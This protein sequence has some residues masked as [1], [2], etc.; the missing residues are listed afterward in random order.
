MDNEISNLDTL[1]KVK[2]FKIL[3]L[4]VRSLPKK[5]DQIRLMLLKSN[6]EVITLSETW[7]NNSVSSISLS[8]DDYKLFRQDR[9]HVLVNK[10]K[11]GGLLTYV[12]NDLAADCE[13]LVDISTATKDIEAQWSQIT[14]PHC[15]NVVVCNVYRP[16]TGKLDNAIKY[17]DECLKGFDLGKVEVYIMGDMNVNYKN[18]SAVDFKKLNFFIKSN[19]LSQA[20]DKTTRNTDKTKSL[21]DLILTNSLYVKAAGTLEH[22]I[23]DHQP[24]FIVKKKG[25]DRRP[26]VIFEGRTYR[27]YDKE[28][29]K[30]RLLSQ[31]WD[32]YFKI[33]DPDEAWDHILTKFMPVIDEMCPIRS[34]HIKNYK[35]DW[36]NSELL[37][38]IK[39]RDYFYKKAKLTGD[40]DDWNIA[41]HL[42]NVTNANIRQAKRDFIVDELQDNKSD[43][44]QF[45]KT[46][47]SVIPSDKGDARQNINLTQQGVKIAK[48]KV[49]DHIND[50]FINIGKQQPGNTIHQTQ[51]SDGSVSEEV[52]SVSVFSQSE[53]LKAV[54]S[55]NTSKSLGL[56]NISSFVIKEVFIILIPQITYLFNLSIRM[57]IFPCVWKEALVI[58]IPKCGNLS[59]VKNYRPISLLPIPG[60]LLEKLVH[61]QLSEYLDE[62]SFLTDNQHGFRKNHSTLHSVA[63]VVNYV[64]LK[65]DRRLPTLAAFIDFR[66]V[67]DCVQHPILLDKLSTIGLHKNLVSWFSSYLTGRKQRVLANNV[68]SASK[69]VTQG[70]PQ[71]SVLGPLFY[72]IYANDIAEIMKNCNLALY[73]DDTVLY[74]AGS[75]FNRIVGKMQKDIDAL[76][77]WCLNN[78]I[79]MN[80]DKTNLMLFGQ[81]SMLDKLPSFEINVN[82]TP[83]KAVNNY[84]YLGMTLDCQLNYNKHVQ[85]N[86]AKV[87]VKL[88]Q[89]RRMRYFL[90]TKAAMLVYK[91]MI[92]PML[93]YGD[94]FMSSATVNDRKK[95]QV[96]QNKGLRCALQVDK[97][98]D[99]VELHTE[100]KLCKLN[101]RRELHLMSHMYDMAQCNSNLKARAVDGVKTRSSEKK[102]LKI[103]KPATEKF[104]KSLAYKDP[105]KWNALPT[106]LHQLDTRAKFNSGFKI[107]MA[108]KVK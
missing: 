11:G 73:A 2:G 91:N 104:K 8:L 97:Y 19:G 55:I 90:D 71:G 108:E 41:K 51:A 5:M 103:K 48:S 99:T 62:I 92:L 25:R 30:Q 59:L 23:S 94:I 93:E 81:K 80:T 102:L 22:F 17:L 32:E 101:R 34:F 82:D 18:K 1:N 70:V 60:K 105:K 87:S 43:Y 31:N 36:I 83:I 27:S 47:R 75:N 3:H 46:I 68:Y 13:P 106:R 6:L 33:Q 4:N 57:S 72:I 96:L 84:R 26:S 67:F 54:K 12:R 28:V 9:N 21:L 24:I 15:K 85:K 56:T 69:T 86:I 76:S 61:T 58:P 79:Q 29:M 50:Y 66:K 14:R 45:W 74:I 107:F 100:A 49:A 88:K 10:K 40:E 39:D 16:P 65:M 44:K 35:P 53:V 42:R 77:T 20:I 98:T 38:Q 89:F 63:Q 7:L 64:N 52:W 37:E 78:G 95:L